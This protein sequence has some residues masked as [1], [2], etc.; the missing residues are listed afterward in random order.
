MSLAD[1]SAYIFGVTAGNDV[2]E[3]QWQGGDIQWVRAKGSRGFNAVGPVLVTG[4]R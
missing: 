2:S 4:D 3:R 1:A